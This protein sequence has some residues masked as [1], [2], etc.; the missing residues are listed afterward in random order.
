MRFQEPPAHLKGRIQVATGFE[1]GSEALPVERLIRIGLNETFHKADCLV[2][3]V[4]LQTDNHHR[5]QCFR[6]VRLL[7]QYLQ[8]TVLRLLQLASGVLVLRQRESFL[9]SFDGD[10]RGRRRRLPC[11][12]AYDK[13]LPP[14]EPTQPTMSNATD[15]TAAM[16]RQAMSA[17]QQG[18]AARARDLFLQATARTAD[19]ASL[20]LGLAFAQARLGE[21]QP[22]LDAVDRALSI[23]PRNLRALIFKGDHHAEMGRSRKAL[24]FYQ[25]ALKTA[26]TLSGRPPQD[27]LSGLNRAQ[28][29]CDA[30]ANEYEDY[31]TRAL[32]AD[33][34]RDAAAPQRFRQAIDILFGRREIYYQSPTRFY[35]PGLPQ[36]QFY[37]RHHF[38]WLEALES[39]TEA[40]REELLGVMRTEDSFSPYL[41]SDPDAVNFNDTSNLD[42]TD[43]GAFYLY[44]E[45]RLVED[46]AARCPATLDAMQLAPLPVVE[47]STPHALYSKLAGNTRIPPHCGL[48]NTRLICHL[49]LLVPDNCGG[50]RV[51]SDTH[52][53]QEGKAYVFDDSIE[54]EAWN[55]SDGDRVVLLF[56]IWRPEFDET[57]RALISSTLRAVQSYENTPD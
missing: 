28:A 14:V 49:P 13:R 46:H 26:S 47:G 30:Y 23:E 55:E 33:G 31:L 44:Q 4:G 22:A 25:A 16:T 7:L 8:K 32:H 53:W 9:Y 17:L 36:I 5:L 38:P 54:H 20:W 52:Y 19:E 42:S 35:Y 18:D 29:R 6:V 34:Y 1:N 45:G 41:Q 43:W 51:G 10:T 56:D 24:V 11:Q 2:P 39:R 15:D 3:P 57:E 21:D 40:V 12:I 48:I 27:I 50:L 37:E